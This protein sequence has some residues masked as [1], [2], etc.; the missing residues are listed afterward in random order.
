[1]SD[2]DLAHFQLQDPDP[3]LAHFNC[4]IQI[5]IF[6]QLSILR[7]GFFV[8]PFIVNQLWLPVKQHIMAQHFPGLLISDTIHSSLLQ[9][10]RQA[11]RH[12]N[13]IITH[14]ERKV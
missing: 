4:R 12:S 7:L 13:R 2:P 6:G 1:M 9:A 5:R 3:D 14:T 10:G 8:L 11:G